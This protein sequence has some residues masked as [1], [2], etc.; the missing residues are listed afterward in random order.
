MSAANR[1]GSVTFF[2]LLVGS[3]LT[4]ASTSRGQS[5]EP[6][7]KPWVVIKGSLGDFTGKSDSI[8]ADFNSENE[9][10]QRAQLLNKALKGD[11]AYRWL[12]SYRA[13]KQEESGSVGQARDL[14]GRLKEAKDGRRGMPPTTRPPK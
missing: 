6:G 1:W 2:M 13:R 5:Q 10:R 11:D 4:G 7:S 3:L 12:Y 8:V 9:A 14:L